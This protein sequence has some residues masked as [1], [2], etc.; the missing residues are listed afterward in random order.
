VQRADDL[1]DHPKPES[2]LVEAPTGAARLE[3]IEDPFMSLAP[4]QSHGRAR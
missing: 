3:A 4:M 1:P 2:R